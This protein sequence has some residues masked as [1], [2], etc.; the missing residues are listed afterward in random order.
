[1]TTRSADVTAVVLAAE[2]GERLARALAS[3]AWACERLV[4]D[5]A[6]RVPPGA[7][8][9]GATH[10]S[11]AVALDGLGRAG[12]ILLLGEDE[13]LDAAAASAV[14][15]AVGGTHRAFRLRRTYQAFGR[16][17][18]AAERPVRLVRRPD[19][20]LEVGA[21]LALAI[22]DGDDAPALDGTL[23]VHGVTDVGD[24]L[25]ALD[26]DAAA[27]A[28]M[29][30]QAGRRARVRDLLVG[31]LVASARVL[32]ARSDRRLGWGRW[33]A[34][35]FAGYRVVATYAKLW[36]VARRPSAVSG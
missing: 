35:V 7:R 12:W 33:I 32:V 4:W 30:Q 16:T 36:E 22:G 2:G 18:R 13:S 24:A 20:R 1:V 31:P 34:G 29:L 9:A 27:L 23:L 21:G 11:G 26:A 25:R 14:A 10:V 6:G 28:A 8:A 5:P 15:A 19:A 17:L 3:V